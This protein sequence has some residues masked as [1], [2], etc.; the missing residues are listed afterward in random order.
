MMLRPARHGLARR[1]I[2]LP[3]AGYAT[4]SPGG[5]G[6]QSDAAGIIT[7]TG[8]YKYP[9]AIDSQSRRGNV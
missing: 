7:S 9:V 3:V 4:C 5:S 1:G 2:M 6:V 8:L